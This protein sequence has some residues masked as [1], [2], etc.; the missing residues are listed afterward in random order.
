[1]GESNSYSIQQAE[2]VTPT[3][4]ESAQQI[5]EQAQQQA[6]I[7]AQPKTYDPSEVQQE[8]PEWLPEKFENAE[9]LA[10]AY[11][12]L[13]TKLGQPKEEEVVKE[14]TTE[15]NY[16][17][18]IS[19]ASEEYAEKGE[20]SE[21]TYQK[22]QQQGLSKLMID[23]YIA[24]QQAIV[25]Q[26]QMEITNEIGGIQ[27]YQKLSAWAAEALS[28]SDLEAYNETVESGT[29]AQAKFAI[30]SLYSQF[31]AAGAPKLAQGAVNGTGVPPFQSRAQVTAAMSNPAYKN[32]PAYREEVLQRLARSNV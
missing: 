26:Q 22:L 1:M 21:D 32:D 17:T 18:A 3:L 30:K 24:G 27:E 10:K 19:D 2:E 7:E 8:R 13:E 12:E 4:E 23:N 29:V 11:G 9:D 28:D 14:E 20:L 5:D 6:E 25:N 16:E 15:V 31:Q